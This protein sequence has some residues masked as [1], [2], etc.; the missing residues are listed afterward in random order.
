MNQ[1]AHLWPLLTAAVALAQLDRLKKGNE[2]INLDAREAIMWLDEVTSMP[3]IE[4]SG[5]VQLEGVDQAYTT[6]EEVEQFLLPETLLSMEDTESEEDA[7]Y[8]E[9]LESSFAQ[10]DVSDDTSISSS[11]SLDDPPK[12]PQSAESA[13]SIRKAKLANGDAKAPAAVINSP[14]RTAR[15]SVDIPRTGKPP[16]GTI[17]ISL[18]PLFNHIL[19]TINNDTNPN[20]ALANFILLT[21]DHTKQ[22]IAQKFGVRAKRLEQLRDAVAREDREYRNHLVVNKLESADPKPTIST[23]KAEKGTLEQKDADRSKSNSSNDEADSEDEDVVLLKRAPRGPQAQTA[24]NQRVFDPNEFGRVNQHH[25]PRGGRGGFGAFRGRG[26]SP[27]G[28]G[29]FA[30]RGGFG[31]PGPPFRAPPAPRHDPNQ[32][33]DPNSFSRPSVRVSNARGAR[34]KLWEPN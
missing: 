20:A 16:K 25:G 17:P 5:R 8:P 31:P 18:R 13:L 2:R 21:N 6:W 26:A 23:E 12:T 3:A 34:K 7:D 27:R 14:N 33:I 29:G 10:L 32:P 11:H 22:M 30:S 4:T 19:W 24:N 9:Y 28:R 15:N 1:A